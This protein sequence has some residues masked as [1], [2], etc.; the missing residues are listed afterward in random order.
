M[1]KGEVMFLGSSF[2]RLLLGVG[3]VHGVSAIAAAQVPSPAPAAAASQSTITAS[4][5]GVTFLPGST[6]QLVIERDGKRYLVD[7]ANSSIREVG[8]AVG[9]APSDAP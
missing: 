6:S 4:G 9:Q 1:P 8:E 5:L 2:V 7:I 3:V